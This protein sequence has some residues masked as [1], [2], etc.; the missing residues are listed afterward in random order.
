MLKIAICTLSAENERLET[1]VQVLRV[2]TYH[3]SMCVQYIRHSGTHHKNEDGTA[4]N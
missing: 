1:Y 3:E 2:H 4:L